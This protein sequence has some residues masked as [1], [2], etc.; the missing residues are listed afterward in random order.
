[1]RELLIVNPVET[2]ASKIGRSTSSVRQLCGRFGN[3]GE[4]TQV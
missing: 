3:P 4:G 1:M 2:V